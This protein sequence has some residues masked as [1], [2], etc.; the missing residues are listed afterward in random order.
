MRTSDALL[1]TYAERKN[2]E[3][4]IFNIDRDLELHGFRRANRTTDKRVSFNNLT[5][6]AQ[7]SKLIISLNRPTINFDWLLQGEL[8]SKGKTISI[9]KTKSYDE[10]IENV[11]KILK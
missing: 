7:D 9:E 4:L 8:Q 2:I 1:K 11:N 10:F 6:A 3:N 5:Y